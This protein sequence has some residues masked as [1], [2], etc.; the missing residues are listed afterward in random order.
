[1]Q[2]LFIFFTIITFWATTLFASDILTK[3]SEVEVLL[4]QVKK[5]QPEE[6][7]ELM[8]QLKLK[9]RA[10]NQ[11]SRTRAMMDLQ[12]SFAKKG[13]GSNTQQKMRATV[14]QNRTTQQQSAQRMTQG[15]QQKGQR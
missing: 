15:G 13:K 8:N 6:K 12:K 10:M 1:M 3:P 11:E 14:Q 4:T 9:L 5:A 2:T 7:R